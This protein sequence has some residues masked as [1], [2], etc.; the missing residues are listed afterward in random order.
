[1]Y[2]S[3]Y[4]SAI[5]ER[6]FELWAVTLQNEPMAPHFTWLPGAWESCTFFPRLQRD[7]LKDWLGP[8]LERDHPEVKIIVHDSQKPNLYHDSQVI[9][10]DPDAAKYVAG[11]GIHW[12]TGGEAFD[13]VKRTGNQLNLF[14]LSGS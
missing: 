1:L 5:K 9:M 2:F 11:F 4:I 3:K 14:F 8:T 7:F 6:G 12:Y 10:D 13:I